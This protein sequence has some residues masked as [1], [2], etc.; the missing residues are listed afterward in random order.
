MKQMISNL[1]VILQGNV[2]TE[3]DFQFPP[4][5]LLAKYSFLPITSFF[6]DE[7]IAIA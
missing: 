1:S 5:V 4:T 6:P 7:S 3:T 2:L